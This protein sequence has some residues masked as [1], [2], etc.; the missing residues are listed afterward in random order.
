[1]LEKLHMPWIKRSLK[2]QPLIFS[3]CQWPFTANIG[4]PHSANWDIQWA[5]SLNEQ[6]K[7]SSNTLSKVKRKTT[8]TLKKKNQKT[9]T[10]YWREITLVTYRMFSCI[11]LLIK[12]F[13]LLT[14]K[15]QSCINFSSRRLYFAAISKK[16][17]I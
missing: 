9:D 11:C 10:G 3:V 15:N 13:L 4:M 2:K 17:Y 5:T 14:N 16:I 6:G 1:M 7:K 12:A 8:L